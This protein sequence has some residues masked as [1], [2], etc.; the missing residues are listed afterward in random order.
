MAYLP[1]PVSP[2]DSQQDSHNEYDEHHSNYSTCYN[3]ILK[4]TTK[5]I[6]MYIVDTSLV[7]LLH[8]AWIIIQKIILI[9]MII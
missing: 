6:I 7:N 2:E 3:S 5:Q 4:A 1:S 8:E 9:L